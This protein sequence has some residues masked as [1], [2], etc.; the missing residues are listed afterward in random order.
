MN[1]EF[2][3]YIENAKPFAQPILK[4]LRELIH[5]V[6][7]AVEEK[8]KWGF[9]HFDY[10]GVMMCSMAA[11]K[12]HAV[13][14][15]WKA[16]IM[17]DPDN[18]LSVAERAS[19]GHMGR[20]QSLQDLPIDKILI[21]YIKEA[22]RLNDEGIKLPEKVKVTEKKELVLADDFKKAIN[23]HPKALDVFDNFSYTNKKEY[24][25]WIEGSKSE[26]T[27]IKRMEQAAEWISEG[28]IRHWKYQK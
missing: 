23:R 26:D 15:F 27:R 16:S 25:E 18:I 28:K 7:P 24:I 3:K 2:D 11:F 22:V 12:E 9:P 19:M 5:S 6:C 8:I 17:D 1:P 21:K 13:F 20:L 10:K 14:G 4:H